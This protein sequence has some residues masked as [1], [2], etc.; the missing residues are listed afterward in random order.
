[1]AGIALGGMA[2]G[3][4]ALPA[5]APPR[6]GRA[7]ETEVNAARKAPAPGPPADLR[8]GAYSALVGKAR[9]IELSHWEIAMDSAAFDALEHQARA[10]LPPS[11]FAFCAAGADDEITAAENSARWRA[12]RLRPHILRAVAQVDPGVMIL[13]RHAA[14]PI[15]IAPTGR[16]RLFH[17]DG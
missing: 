17:C 14:T 5:A 10:Q 11:S 12:L 2:T 8:S 3:I 9:P 7:R 4:L 16:H 15:M 1:P 13:G 6:L